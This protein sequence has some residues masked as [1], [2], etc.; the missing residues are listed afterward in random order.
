MYVV[1]IKNMRRINKR[2]GWSKEKKKFTN[3][4][5]GCNEQY[6]SFASEDVRRL[7]MDS[8]VFV[9]SCQVSTAVTV[10]SQTHDA[11]DVGC[12]VYLSPSQRIRLKI[13]L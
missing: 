5:P 1:Q 7:K 4:D 2:V 6:T 12:D 10:G 8:K 9:E 13:R 11:F 3:I